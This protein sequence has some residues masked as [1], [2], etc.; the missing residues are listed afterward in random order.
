[1]VEVLRD[2][3]QLSPEVHTVRYEELCRDPIPV[4]GDLFQFLDLELNAEAKD[5]ATQLFHTKSIGRW[6]HYKQYVTDTREDME[7]VFA[8]MQP[9]L[10]SLG[11]T[12]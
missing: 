10:E 3:G 9:E 11:Y 6:N 7:A 12:E 8:A 5:F 1:M 4:L 2:T